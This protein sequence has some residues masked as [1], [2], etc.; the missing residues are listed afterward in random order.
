[1][2]LLVIIA[3]QLYTPTISGDAEVVSLSVEV[4]IFRPKFLRHFR[5][6]SL[7]RIAK[8]SGIHQRL[9]VYCVFFRSIIKIRARKTRAGLRANQDLMKLNVKVNAR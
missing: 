5:D 6:A 4:F 1:M 7:E 3:P 9:P 2:I 8:F